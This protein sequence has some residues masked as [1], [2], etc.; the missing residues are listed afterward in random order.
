MTG[1]GSRKGET[2]L[3]RF[4]V[5]N[6]L[7]FKEEVSLDL[8][9]ARNLNPLD[10]IVSKKGKG[11]SA[12]PI[13]LLYGANGSGKSNLFKAMKYARDL[14]VIGTRGDQT[15]A[16]N[17]FKLNKDCKSAPTVF[18]FFFKNEGVVYDYG[19]AIQED[20][21][22]EEW[23]YG[24]YSRKEVKLFTRKVGKKSKS[25]YEFGYKLRGRSKKIADRLGFVAD[26]TRKNQLFL[27]EAYDRNVKAIEDAIQWFTR[28]LVLI[29]PQ[30]Q[31]SNLP[32]RTSR[33][34]EF[35]EY[36][37]DLLRVADTGIS[38]IHAEE[39]KL[40]IDKHFPDLPDDEK[41]DLLDQ[42]GHIAKTENQVLRLLH[43][44]EFYTVSIDRETKTPI[45]HTLSTVHFSNSSG[46]VEFK[47]SEESDG[48]I[49]LMHI[50]LGL[51]DL[52]LSDA[53]YIIDEIDRSLH[54]LLC[55]WIIDKF[56]EKVRAEEVKGQLIVTTHQTCLLNMKCLRHDE[57]N[58]VEKDKD[59]ATHISS[60]VEF[61][62]RGDLKLEKGYLNGR[63]GAIPFIGDAT[64]LLR[65]DNDIST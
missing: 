17:K 23:L 37:A 32:I 11:V 31:Y 62:V 14:I 19:F 40:D 20:M 44:G 30:T 28:K 54:P 2:M 64:N 4:T 7:S 63:F 50:A 15:L 3:L 10:L 61:H 29:S 42:I 38:E 22:I 55:L 9:P 45:L 52:T 36:L 43:N 27:T 46:N 59:G 12:L 58:F 5:S 13:S 8:L 65:P 47:T 57:I 21:I 56:I 16:V 18:S 60:L 24:T 25:E 53:V 51:L 1:Y 39:K 26:G 35:S 41:Q 34:N 6:F 33:D 49:R 48:S